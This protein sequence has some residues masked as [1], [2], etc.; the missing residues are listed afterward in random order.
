MRRLL[1]AGVLL[2]PALAAAVALEEGKFLAVR[3]SE[4][5]EL[6]RQ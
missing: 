1:Q 5:D 2:A 3:L 4:E 6:I